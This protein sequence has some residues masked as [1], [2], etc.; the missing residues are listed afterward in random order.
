MRTGRAAAS[1]SGP[2]GAAR[3]GSVPSTGANGTAEAGRLLSGPAEG[4]CG[5]IASDGGWWPGQEVES[6]YDCGITPGWEACG[7]G[8]ASRMPG[9]TSQGRPNHCSAIASAQANHS[10]ER[11]SCSAD[12]CSRGPLVLVA[13]PLPDGGAASE[14]CV[15]SQLVLLGEELRV[16]LLRK[17]RHR[18]TTK[19]D[20]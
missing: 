18:S 2:T 6:G 12:A 14:V 4:C 11:R 20:A 10:A 3:A 1:G 16:S 15:Q 8:S 13:L 9:P 17:G 7:S 19:K 5:C